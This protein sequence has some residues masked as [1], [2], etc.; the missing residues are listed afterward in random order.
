VNKKSAGHKGTNCISSTGALLLIIL[1]Q[2]FVHF[3]VFLNNYWG[4]K[5]VFFDC[6]GF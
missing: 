4:C 6:S 5:K 2:L 1:R 3:I